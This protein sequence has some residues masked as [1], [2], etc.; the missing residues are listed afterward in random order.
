MHGTHTVY[1]R[2]VNVYGNPTRT[3]TIA[4]ITVWP[5]KLPSRTCG[6]VQIRRARPRASATYMLFIVLFTLHG[7]TASKPF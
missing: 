6:R 7:I 2:D 4:Q 5:A 1:D 3:T